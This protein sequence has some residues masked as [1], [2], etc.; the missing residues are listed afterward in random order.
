MVD[1][2]KMYAGTVDGPA[3]ARWTTIGA[4]VAIGLGASASVSANDGRQTVSQKYHRIRRTQLTCSVVVCG[5]AV[6]R[7]ALAEKRLFLPVR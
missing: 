1:G 4:C 5:R 6:S 7:L 3:S 2:C